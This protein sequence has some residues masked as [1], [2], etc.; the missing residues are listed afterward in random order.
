M[1]ER[2]MMK[3]WIDDGNKKIFVFWCGMGFI[4]CK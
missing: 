2:W 4:V 1:N 3:G